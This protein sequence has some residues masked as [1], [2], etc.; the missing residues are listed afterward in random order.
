[1]VGADQVRTDLELASLC[2]YRL[3]GPAALAFFP[4]TIEALSGAVRLLVEEGIGFDVLG[5]GSNV[6]VSDQGMVQPLL[7]LTEMRALRVE[8]TRILA[9][10]GVRADDLAARA[11]EAGLGGVEFLHRLPG[12]MGGAAFMNARAFGQELSQALAAARVLNGKGE[13]KELLLDAGDF[14]YK[15]SPFSTEGYLVV[16]MT[17]DLVRG[18][19]EAIKLRMAQNEA[20][21]KSKREMDY[22]SCGCVFKNPKRGGPSAGTLIDSCGLKGTREGGAWVS[23]DHANFIVHDGKATARQVRT[24]ME[25]VQEE[26]ERKT[27]QILEFEVRFLGLW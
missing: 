3:G 10:A 19:P 17:L 24:L 11:A 4:P 20:H 22:P 25:R 6:L 26:V 21:R 5:C 2:T 27:G 16:E 7:V 12:S 15:R 9:E 23:L 13:L 14:G 18:D 1:M 8:G